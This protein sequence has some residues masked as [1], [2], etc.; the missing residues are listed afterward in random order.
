MLEG[1]RIMPFPLEKGNMNN[2]FLQLFS[3]HYL[4]S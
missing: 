2:D 3:A 4:F 1:E